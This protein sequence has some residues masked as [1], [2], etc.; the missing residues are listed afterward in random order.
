MWMSFTNFIYNNI[1]KSYSPIWSLIDNL[2][3]KA[4]DNS[5]SRVRLRA[6]VNSSVGKKATSRPVA[7]F[8][9]TSIVWEQSLTDFTNRI[10][11]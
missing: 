2:I 4:S 6:T 3:S 10:I 1:L 8:I 5:S 7:F 9:N 11:T